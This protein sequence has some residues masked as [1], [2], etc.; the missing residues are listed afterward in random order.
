LCFAIET[1][2]SATLAP[3]PPL[4]RLLRLQRL[5]ADYERKRGS[6]APV[7]INVH[8][9]YLEDRWAQEPSA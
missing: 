9:R 8:Q 7:S 1:R 6:G 2:M 3:R 5:Q 4:L